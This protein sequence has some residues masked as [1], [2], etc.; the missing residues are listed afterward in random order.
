[1]SGRRV[2]LRTHLDHRHPV[3][4]PGQH[5]GGRQARSTTADHRTS[6]SFMALRVPPPGTLARDHAPLAVSLAIALA[7]AITAWAAFRWE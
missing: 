5:Q 6:K 4:G 3:P 1:M 7:A 2:A